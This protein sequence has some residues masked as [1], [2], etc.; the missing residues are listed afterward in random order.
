MAVIWVIR[1]MSQVTCISSQGWKRSKRMNLLESSSVLLIGVHPQD[2]PQH[3]LEFSPS[4]APLSL[5]PGT[6]EYYPGAFFQL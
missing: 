1:P 6:V 5:L 2:A 3:T 4:L